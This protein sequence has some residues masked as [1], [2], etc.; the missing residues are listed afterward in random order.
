MKKKTAKRHTAVPPTAIKSSTTGSSAKT[1]A[2]APAK[3]VAAEQVKPTAVAIASAPAKAAA[4]EPVKTTVAAIETAPVKASG[5]CC[6]GDASA[7]KAAGHA[8][9]GGKAAA[10]VSAE[11]TQLIAALG[12]SDADLAR[13]AAAAL[14][15]HRS[16]TAVEALIA[17]LENRDGF[18]HSVVRSAAAMSLGQLGDARAIPALVAAVRDPIADASAEAVRALAAL[19]HPSAVAPLIDVVVNHDG[20]FLNNVRLAAVRALSKFGGPEAR[21]ALRAVAGNFSED[22]VIRGAAQSSIEA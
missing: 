21:G 12:S 9:T 4:A 6:H 7:E 3:I 18:F 13:D 17:V 19:G 22:A 10:T 2:A 8:C 5:A 11:A 1:I 16:D 20:F 14:A 15:A